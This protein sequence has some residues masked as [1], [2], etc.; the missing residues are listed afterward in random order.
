MNQNI[1]QKIFQYLIIINI[2]VIIIL[3]AYSTFLENSTNKIINFISSPIYLIPWITLILLIFFFPLFIKKE[4][5]YYINFF[6]IHLP[7]ILFVFIIVINILTSRSYEITIKENEKTNLSDIAH[8][9][10]INY[11]GTAS[12]KLSNI[13][14][15]N[16][17]NKNISSFIDITDNNKKFKKIISINK[18]V[19]IGKI[20]FFQKN[21]ALGIIEITFTFENNEYNIFEQQNSPIITKQGNYFE[22]YPKDIYNN[23]ILYI[24]KIY[25]KD[26]EILNFGQ[27]TTNNDFISIFPPEEFN[28]S[29]LKEDYKLISILQASYKPF[30]FILGLYSII[31]LIFL[32]YIFWGKNIIQ[33]IV[34]HRLK[35][36]PF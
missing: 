16:G 29:I 33:D 5:K 15:T 28:F 35:N 1:V 23:K 19:K 6:I 31:F 24:W 2:I 13:N 3:S 9:L 14:L 12:L 30:N 27:F 22:I 11:T 25:N 34:Y 21:W 7:F 8:S 36:K 4:T 17:K 32:F 18:P 26:N 20:K 10:G